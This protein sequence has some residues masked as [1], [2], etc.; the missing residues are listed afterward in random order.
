MSAMDGNP[1]YALASDRLESQQQAAGSFLNPDETAM[2]SASIGATLAL[3]YEQRTAN[4]IAYEAG[5]AKAFHDDKLS[6][7]G[8]RLWKLVA[9]QIAERLGL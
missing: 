5:L 9:D 2:Q 8:F 1:H 3:A 4:L 6:E 7:N